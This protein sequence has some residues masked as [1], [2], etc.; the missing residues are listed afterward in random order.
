M[1]KVEVKSQCYLSN[2]VYITH[3][4]RGVQ[5]IVELS[6]LKKPKDS[7]MTITITE[8]DIKYWEKT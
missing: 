4:L 6:Y 5:E 3:D 7:D 8:T 1:Y 2:D